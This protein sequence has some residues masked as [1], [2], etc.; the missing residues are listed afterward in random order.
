MAGRR[1]HLSPTARR[2][3]RRMHVQRYW[4]SKTRAVSR[5]TSGCIPGAIKICVTGRA[6][7]TGTPAHLPYKRSSIYVMAALGFI[8]FWQTFRVIDTEQ[9]QKVIVGE[10]K[11]GK[12]NE[13]TRLVAASTRL[14]AVVSR[15]WSAIGDISS[16]RCL[17][18]CQNDPSYRPTNTRER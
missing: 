14:E 3:R 18:P 11:A 4:K 17:A 2:R 7:W 12:T 9:Q 13:I 10:G 6:D 8:Y 16:P 5:R 15:W 1:I